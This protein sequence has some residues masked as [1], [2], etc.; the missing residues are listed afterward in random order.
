MS[1]HLNTRQNKCSLKDMKLYFVQAAGLFSRRAAEHQ[2]R[3][4]AFDQW[5]RAL[6]LST[7]RHAQK[8]IYLQGEEEDPVIRGKSG[9]AGEFPSQPFCLPLH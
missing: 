5:H 6:I 9:A 2:L 3:L 7:R 1:F 4:L 8:Y